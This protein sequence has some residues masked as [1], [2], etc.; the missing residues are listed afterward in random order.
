MNIIFKKLKKKFKESN[1]ISIEKHQMSCLCCLPHNQH[2][3]IIVNNNKN[4]VLLILE[5]TFLI[6][7]M[8]TRKS[9]GILNTEEYQ[10]TEMECIDKLSELVYRKSE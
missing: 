3:V 5:D 10:S 6:T 1:F 8:R 4:K 2:E 7:E 9:D